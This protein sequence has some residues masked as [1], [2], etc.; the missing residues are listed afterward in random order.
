MNVP[1]RGYAAGS[2]STIALRTADVDPLTI[3][4]LSF[5]LT[6]TNFSS[7]QF[8]IELRFL[9]RSETVSGPTSR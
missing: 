8:R 4:L 6:I 2:I 9:K 7:F 5:I 1:G 3:N